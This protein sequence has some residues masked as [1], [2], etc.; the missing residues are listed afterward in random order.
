MGGTDR[1]TVGNKGRIVI[2]APIRTRHA[3]GEGTVLVAVDGEDGVV[4]MERDRALRLV[5]AGL[6]GSDPVATLL[7]ER[8]AEAHHED[9]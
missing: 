1:V 7:R 8:R 5:R 6:A 3:W 4:L 9:G 2:P